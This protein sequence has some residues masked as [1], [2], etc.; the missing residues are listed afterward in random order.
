MKWRKMD[1]LSSARTTTCSP[2][3]R[4]RAHPFCPIPPT[5]SYFSPLDP[6]FYGRAFHHRDVRLVLTHLLPHSH[7]TASGSNR[8]RLAPASGN[9][10]P[11]PP[12]TARCLSPR[13]DPVVCHRRRSLRLPAIPGPHR[14]PNAHR[15][16]RPLSPSARRCHTHLPLQAATSLASLCVRQPAR[17]YLTQT[18][19]AVL[20]PRLES[21]QS[22]NITY[23]D[24]AGSLNTA[25]I[26]SH[27]RH[28]HHRRRLTRRHREEAPPLEACQPCS[29]AGSFDF[30]FS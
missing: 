7:V 1:L 9:R 16:R 18:T 23:Q 11:P 13:R 15:R 14:E 3:G 12:S 29:V 28:T 30:I 17:C 26:G 19:H 4:P 21:N 24:P 22:R 5:C 10:A 2:R 8:L 27:A 6:L 25:S 20:P